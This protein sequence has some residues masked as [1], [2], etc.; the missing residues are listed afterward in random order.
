MKFT[1]TIDCDNAAFED[2]LEFEVPR[3]LEIATHKVRSGETEFSLRDLNG[4]TCGAAR[5]EED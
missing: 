2:G 3:I 5:F 1:L 4:N